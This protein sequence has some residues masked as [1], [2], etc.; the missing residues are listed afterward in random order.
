MT[1]AE[2]LVCGNPAAWNAREGR[3]RHE[4]AALDRDHVPLVAETPPSDTRR[5]KRKPPKE[6]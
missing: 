5:T 6:S 1:S 3:W 2:C 4:D